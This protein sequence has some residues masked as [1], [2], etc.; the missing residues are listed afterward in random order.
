MRNKVFTILGVVSL[1]TLTACSGTSST[2]SSE[3]FPSD[4]PSPTVE[5]ETKEPSPSNSGSFEIIEE[6]IEEDQSITCVLYTYEETAP[7]QGYGYGGLS[8]DWE[9]YHEEY[10]SSTEE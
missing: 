9:T 4:M 5:F 10:G 1:F 7:Y 8:C 3:S 2:A 6:V